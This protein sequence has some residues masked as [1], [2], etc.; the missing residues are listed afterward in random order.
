[1]NKNLK[2]LTSVK[3]D[4]STSLSNLV[5]DYNLLEKQIEE[6]SLIQDDEDKDAIVYVFLSAIF[7]SQILTTSSFQTQVNGLQKVWFKN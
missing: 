4:L 2:E 3:Q 6:L 1:M 5:D 7:L